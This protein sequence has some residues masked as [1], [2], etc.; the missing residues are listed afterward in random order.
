VGRAPKKAIDGRL[1][2]AIGSFKAASKP[3]ARGQAPVG[4]KAAIVLVE[5]ARNT[6]QPP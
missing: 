6:Q 4:L 3:K 1:E 2:S 5:L